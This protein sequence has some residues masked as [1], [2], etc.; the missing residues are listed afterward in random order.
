M[1]HTTLAFYQNIYDNQLEGKAPFTYS[2]GDAQSI[3]D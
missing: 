3:V 2:F 1:V